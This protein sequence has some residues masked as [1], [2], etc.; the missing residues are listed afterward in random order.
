MFDDLAPRLQEILC[1]LHSREIEVQGISALKLC[2]FCSPLIYLPQMPIE[3]V[4]AMKAL[5]SPRAS[6]IRTV[7]RFTSNIG[8]AVASGIL[9]GHECFAAVNVVAHV[10]LVS[11]S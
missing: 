5:D 8:L 3:I 9:W 4:L 7:Q 6:G 11:A 2:M 10:V 1:V